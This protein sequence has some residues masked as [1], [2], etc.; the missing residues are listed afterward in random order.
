MESLNF[1]YPDEMK[2]SQRRKPPLPPTHNARRNDNK[3]VAD[4]VVDSSR[5]YDEPAAIDVA[6]TNKKSSEIVTVSVPALIYLS[7]KNCNEGHNC[8][9]FWL[10]H[11][12][13]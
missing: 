2:P 6:T 12:N 8:F 7:G 5:V 1:S 11:N 13:Q 4:S 9:A 3:A 10:F